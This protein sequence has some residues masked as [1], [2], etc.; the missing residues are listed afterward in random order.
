MCKSIVEP[1]R[2]QV[3]MWRMLIACWIL[4]TTQ[5][6]SEYVI[7]FLFHCNNS[8][9]KASQ[10]YVR[11][12]LPAFFVLC[13]VIVLM[14]VSIL[15]PAVYRIEIHVWEKQTT[16]EILNYTFLLFLFCLYSNISCVENFCD[17]FWKA[18]T[19]ESLK[20]IRSILCL[21]ARLN[22]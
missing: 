21:Y 16:V 1:D 4:N 3:T 15:I 5:I 8:C 12:T 10:C 20:E 7:L 18:S 19:V 2:P 11:R 22:N 9:S 13:P 14:L 6:T 17:T